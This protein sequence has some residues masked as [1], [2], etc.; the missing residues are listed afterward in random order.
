MEGD[1]GGSFEAADKETAKRIGQRPS[2]VQPS[3]VRMGQKRRDVCKSL[4]CTPRPA[5][6]HTLAQTRLCLRHAPGK[7][8]EKVQF[9]RHSAGTGIVS[10]AARISAG[11]RTSRRAS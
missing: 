8:I 6:M 1:V 7:G 10:K 2:H 4:S 11:T 3:R 9:R 5:A